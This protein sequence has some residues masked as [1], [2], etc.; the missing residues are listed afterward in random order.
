MGTAKIFS[1]N[2]SVSNTPFNN[3]PTWVGDTYPRSDMYEI[4]DTKGHGD[5]I[6]AMIKY[7]HCPNYHGRKLLLFKDVTL[8]TLKLAK[9]IDPH[10]HEGRPNLNPIARFE[11]TADGLVLALRSMN[12]TTEGE[13]VSIAP[14]RQI[15]SIRDGM[16]CI[17]LMIKLNQHL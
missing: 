5:Y 8:E 15:A 7:D 12:I 4:V 13:L 11:P 1:S 16:D 6:L 2:G 14:I 17:R 10:F 3:P 9:K